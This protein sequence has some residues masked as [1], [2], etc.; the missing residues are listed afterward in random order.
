MIDLLPTFARL[1][2][3]K[4]PNGRIIDGHDILPLM[5]GVVG[6]HSPY[7]AFYYY[8]MA[9]LQAVRS[10]RWKLHLPLQAKWQNFSG[11]TAASTAELYD[12]KADLGET[13]NLAKANP[14]VVMR[15]LVLAEKAR[16]DLGDID[17][18]G[19]NQRPAG[20]I[21]DP[22]PRRLR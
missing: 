3:A 19:K 7:E 11:R 13:R 1:A 5:T 4:I 10:G 22:T 8:Y 17:R 21:A 2:P 20:F 18:P 14:E 12:L 16:E 6:A 9:Q 15:M